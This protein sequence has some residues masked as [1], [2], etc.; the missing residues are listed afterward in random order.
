MGAGVLKVTVLYSSL[1]SKLW[2]DRV[3]SNLRRRCKVEVQS[4]VE[5][6]ENI[7]LNDIDEGRFKLEIKSGTDIILVMGVPQDVLLEVPEVAYKA[8]IR[9]VLIPVEDPEWVPLGLQNQVRRECLRY[10]IECLFPRPF[11]SFNKAGGESLTKLLKCIGT[12][13]FRV[14]VKDGVVKSVVV[15]RSSPCGASYH[16]AEKLVGCKV[17][18]VARVASLIHSYYCLASRKIDHAL[19]DSLLH[20]SCKITMESIKSSINI[21]I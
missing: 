8:S 1:A 2:I 10:G 7:T 16:V 20:V 21:F 19:G 18:D 6:P 13:R 12:P 4:V 15:E 11:C 3:L 17:G 14:G 9:E 5:V